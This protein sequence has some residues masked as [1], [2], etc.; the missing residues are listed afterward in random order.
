MVKAGSSLMRSPLTVVM[1]CPGGFGSEPGPGCNPGV[2]A[3]VGVAGGGTTAE[4]VGR[5]VATWRGPGAAATLLGGV[6]FTTTS[7]TATEPG[8]RAAGGL[9]S[10]GAGV[11]LDG[12]LSGLGV[13]VVSGGCVGDSWVYPSIGTSTAAARTAAKGR[14]RCQA[15][16]AHSENTHEK[17]PKRWLSNGRYS[18][19]RI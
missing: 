2:V 16:M 1:V 11:G 18:V 6:G 19:G 5:G 13:S 8:D 14:K 3:N 9:A 17:G 12:L 10:A 15:N 4:T 7:G